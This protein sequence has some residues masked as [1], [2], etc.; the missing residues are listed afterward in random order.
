MATTSDV[1]IVGAGIMGCSAAF[2]LAERGLKVTVLEKDNIGA[3]GT[4]RSSGIIRQHYSN[5]LT[6]RMAL[7]CLRVFQHFDDAVGGD[8]GFIE[9]GWV[10]LAPAKDRPGMEANVALQQSVGIQTH[11]ISATELR[12]LVPGLETADMVSAA[13]E[14]ES[15]VAD[16]H[17]TVN[18]YADAARRSGTSIKVYTEVTGIRFEG[19]NVLGVDTADGRFDA[20]VVINCAGP[21]GA[22]V[23]GMAGIDIPV[24]PTRIQVSV[25]RRPVGYEDSHPV[26]IDFVNG[27]YLRAETGVLTLV[28]SIDPKEADVAVDPDDYPEYIDTDFVT[29]MAEGFIRRYPPME[30]AES[31]GGYSGL[32]AVTPDWHPII[33]E[34]PPGSGCYL[35]TGFS[36]HGF[37]LAPAIG[38]MMADTITGASDPQFP[39][40]L[41]RLSRYQEDDLVRGLYDYSIVG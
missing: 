26:V 9:T 25:F 11:L 28:G 4:G 17:L 6:A 19:D 15:G 12:D 39:S 16:P 2:H 31:R 13:Y 36:G 8:C 1:V 33:D 20:P 32:Y 7:H 23:A 14:P 35:C 18:A 10:G 38:L 29:E 40:D 5:E 21:W 22:I 3:G 30:L 24:K 41:F 37:K 34:A 27:I